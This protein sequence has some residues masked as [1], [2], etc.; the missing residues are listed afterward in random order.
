MLFLEKNENKVNSETAEGSNGL[1]S[2]FALS[3]KSSTLNYLSP[4]KKERLFEKHTWPPLFLISF[5]IEKLRH[6]FAATWMDP[7]FIK[8]SEVSQKEKDKY[9][10]M[11][12][13]HGI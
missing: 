3:D 8:L 9:H 13:I 7:E 4:V 12:F 6:T 11:S 2:R 5:K 1:E 10:I